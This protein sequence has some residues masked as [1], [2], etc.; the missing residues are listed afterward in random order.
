MSIVRALEA[1]KP[2]EW[3]TFDEQEAVRI[4][5]E[6][7]DRLVMLSSGDRETINELIQGRRA[8]LAE[9]KRLQAHPPE[10]LT[11]MA[12]SKLRVH[13][14]AVFENRFILQSAAT[15]Q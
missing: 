12:R 9:A 4:P 10:P 1:E 8:A 7:G 13:D 6:N 11:A 5:I 15:N 14:V 3:T 2:V